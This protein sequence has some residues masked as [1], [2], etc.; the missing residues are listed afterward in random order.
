MPLWSSYQDAPSPDI[1]P[2]GHARVRDRIG[3]QVHVY[4]AGLW[5]VSIIL[6]TFPAAFMTAA[7]A[8]YAILRVWATNPTYGQLFRSW[9]FRLLFLILLFSTLSLFWS[10]DVP[11][12]LDELNIFRLHIPFLLAAWPIL[13]KRGRLWLTAGVCLSA[14]IAAGAQVAQA[15]GLE[16]G[17]YDPGVPNRYPGFVHP[18]STTVVQMVVGCFGIVWLCH[19]RSWRAR[20]A[21]LVVLAACVTGLILAGSR[22]SWIAAAVAWPLT[23]LSSAAVPIISGTAGR[24]AIA[25]IGGVL[26]V[27]AISIMI[28]VI[29]KRDS[30]LQRF[31]AAR[32]EIS[33][34]WVDGDYRSDTG[35]RL[36]QIRL[37]WDLFRHRPMI[38][39]GL[40]SYR[41][42]AVEVA[43]SIPVSPPDEDKTDGTLRQN[44]RPVLEHPHSAVL[45]TA[46][47][48]GVV[49][50][51]LWFAFWLRLFL[52][53]VTCMRV[54]AGQSYYIAL[55]AIVVGLAVSYLLDCQ[56]LSAPGTS[57]L[58][59]VACLALRP[60]DD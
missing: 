14:V 60:T 41:Q 2:F 53:S 3:D 46:V 16:F 33:A 28:V 38:G 19:G 18:S 43:R 32:T 25:S 52:R 48:T 6:G 23:L 44:P 39:H 21:G 45:Y 54:P 27:P 1:D 30:V 29:A 56:N 26:L 50:L 47:T 42:T 9:L 22:A 49:G 55:P 8:A 12:G 24:R 34:A 4:L 5:G 36:F 15:S 40:G 31:D 13:H 35:A 37:S 11:Q 58:M 59:F 7:G 57:I 20:I 17:W 10:V 51:G